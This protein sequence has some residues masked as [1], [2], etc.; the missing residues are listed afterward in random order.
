MMVT[1]YSNIDASSSLMFNVTAYDNINSDP[2][3]VTKLQS[4]APEQGR[5]RALSQASSELF[6][7]HVLWQKEKLLGDIWI[8][9]YINLMIRSVVLKIPCVWKL[10]WCLIEV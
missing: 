10:Q 8:Y 7:I 3:F 4:R 5:R 1:D 2:I 9:A 6:K